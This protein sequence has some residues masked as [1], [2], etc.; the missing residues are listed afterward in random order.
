MGMTEQKNYFLNMKKIAEN[1]D[2]PLSMR[3]NAWCEWGVM[4]RNVSDM[5]MALHKVQDLTSGRTK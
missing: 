4:S 1:V 2:A 5:A 3:I